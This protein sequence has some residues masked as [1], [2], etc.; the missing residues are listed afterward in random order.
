MASPTVLLTVELV[1]LFCDVV[2]FDR[3]IANSVV[4]SRLQ[5]NIVDAKSMEIRQDVMDGSLSI[6]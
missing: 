4:N 2:I 5:L 1:S 6:P 3:G